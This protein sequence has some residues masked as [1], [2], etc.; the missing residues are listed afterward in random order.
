MAICLF[1]I[2]V[3]VNCHAQRYIFLKKRRHPERITFRMPVLLYDFQSETE[4]L[5][6][7]TALA[8]LGTLATAKSA[9]TA[10]GTL[11]TAESALA[12]AGE[13]AL[14]A[15]FTALCLSFV[16]F[17]LLVVVQERLDLLLLLFTLLLHLFHH[18]LH[19]ALAHL[20][21]TAAVTHLFATLCLLLL[22]CQIEV[23]D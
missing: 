8:A 7:C 6:S 17:L 20:A 3:F 14:T 23:V 15:A 12:A 10:L 13:S 16:I 18:G 5:G 21:L 11:A 1:I 9:L 4:A 19:V 2:K 22:V